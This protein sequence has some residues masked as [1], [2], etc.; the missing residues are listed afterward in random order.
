[1]PAAIPILQ[2]TP[3]ALDEKPLTEMSS[4]HAGLL[5]TSRVF[6]SLGIPALIAGN[7]DLKRR[8]R[9][10]I[11]GQM[12]ESLVLLQT[13]G[14]DCVEDMNTIAGDTCLQ[15]GLGYELPAVNTLRD[16]L[17]KF[18]DE[19][20][21]LL[22]PPRDEQKSFILP[23]SKP[24]AGLQSVLAGTV[25][26][27]AGVMD[28]QGCPQTIA[29]VDQD[30]TIIESHKAAAYPHYDGGRGYQPMVAVWAEAN[31]VL[32]AEFRDGNV[33]ARQEPVTCAK[34][35][36][37]ALPQTVTE[38]YFRGDSGCHE[39]GLLQ[40]LNSP[41]REQE[42][43]GRIGFCVSA[44]VSKSLA[45]E[46]AKIDEA[47]WK[48][49]GRDPDG[50]LRQWADV[51]YLPSEPY[52]SKAAGGKPLRYVGLRL[53]KL[54][55][56]LFAD[57]SDR[58]HFAVITNLD[59]SGDRLLPWHREKAGTIEHVHDEIK[60]G[61]GGSRLPSQHVAVNAAWFI[62]ALLS[63]NIASAIKDLCFDPADRTARMKRYRLM[64]VHLAGRMSRF[65]CKLRL[66]FRA[67]QEAISRVAKVWEVF[68]LPT[69][70]TAF[71]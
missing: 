47:A 2:K 34:M 37:D 54:Q 17:N 20:L 40:W 36:F 26:A 44:S 39:R 52:E 25:R 56:S 32:A 4:P 41:D 38:R 19:E 29:T 22:R 70:A 21:A 46:L 28:R 5:V 65:Q 68:Q 16:F 71:S 62:I 33:P 58:M 9:G 14:G 50:T 30:A 49:F 59:W 27:I 60:N 48:T 12:V 18:H 10:L 57:G 7:I 13:V 3:F 1:M 15:R 42:P 69:Q 23:P 61:L 53:L 63:Y 31:L 67:P 51:D 66:R 55:G 24:L 6:R 43:G 11:D 45:A 8:K 35:A 64:I